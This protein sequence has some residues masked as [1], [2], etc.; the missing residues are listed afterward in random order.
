MS[1]VNNDEMHLLNFEQIIVNTNKALRFGSKQP[2]KWVANL[3]E[4]GEQ[5]DKLL[6]SLLQEETAE[7][8]SAV[9]W[10]FC[11]LTDRDNCDFLMRIQYRLCQSTFNESVQ[12][13]EANKYK[14]ATQLI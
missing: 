4:R 8:K 11:Q 2:L 9:Y 10:K 5:W 12:K 6:A 3:V 13:L 14:E 1:N 7:V